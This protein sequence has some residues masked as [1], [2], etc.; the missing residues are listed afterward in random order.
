MDC[1]G[2]DELNFSAWKTLGTDKSMGSRLHSVPAR[3]I[4]AL[5]LPPFARLFARLHDIALAIA[6]FPPH[7]V[8]HRH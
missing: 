1:V 8:L 3:I 4:H 2:L 5:I 7:R 6:H